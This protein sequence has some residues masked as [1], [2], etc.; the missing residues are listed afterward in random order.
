MQN[1]NYQC[2]LM[3]RI[4]ATL[5]PLPK[6]QTNKKNQRTRLLVRT[7]VYQEILTAT[8]NGDSTTTKLFRGATL[9]PLYHTPPVYFANYSWLT[10]AAKTQT[11]STNV[12]LVSP[13]LHPSWI[14][15]HKQIQSELKSSSLST[16]WPRKEKKRKRKEESCNIQFPFVRIH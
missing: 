14:N 3:S 5:H 10:Q 8:T 2:F 7:S 15:T 13:S 16:I 11:L 12:P 9:Q 1:S 4:T 6:K